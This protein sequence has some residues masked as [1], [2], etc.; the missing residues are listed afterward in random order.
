MKEFQVE[1]KYMTLQCKNGMSVQFDDKSIVVIIKKE[2]LKELNISDLCLIYYEWTKKE[3]CNTN[4]ETIKQESDESC[5]EL[6]LIDV[7]KSL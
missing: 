2:I 1:A 5:I 7:V 3:R 4:N 6:L